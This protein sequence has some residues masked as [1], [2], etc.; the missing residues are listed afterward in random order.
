M[1]VMIFMMPMNRLFSSPNAPGRGWFHKIAE[2]RETIGELA[3]S[4]VRSSTPRF[5]SFIHSLMKTF[6]TLTVAMLATFVT[7]LSALG[8][9]PSGTWKFENQGPKG[10]SLES[11]LA[12]QWKD[13]RLTGT[14]ENRAGKVEITEAT[15]ANDEVGFN[16][17]RKIGRGFRKR[18]FTISYTGK[19]ENDTI[20]GTIETV[21]RGEKPVSVPWEATRQ[22]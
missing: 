1:S 21:G 14:I 16:V 10:G 7:S 12:L 9:D 17:I 18:T 13:N 19:L 6:R 2:K 4:R 20:T 11:T 8:A 15:F 22:E 5:S 3:R